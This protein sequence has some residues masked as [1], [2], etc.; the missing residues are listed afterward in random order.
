MMAL[1]GQEQNEFELT[2]R[3][4][5]KILNEVAENKTD[6]KA[7]ME[8]KL[9]KAGA[10]LEYAAFI[11][12]MKA[13]LTD[14]MVDHDESL[15]SDVDVNRLLDDAQELLEKAERQPMVDPRSAYTCLRLAIRRIQEAKRIQVRVK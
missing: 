9:W 13:G 15:G 1:S 3:S 7:A 14:F 11:V 8:R 5:R 6:D 10:D 4:A 12:S 2:L